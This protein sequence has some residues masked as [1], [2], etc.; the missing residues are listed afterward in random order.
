M[1]HPT[2]PPCLGPSGA[3]QGLDLRLTGVEPPGVLS[4]ILAQRWTVCFAPQTMG[5]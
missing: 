5:L 2:L 3:F 4:E 1:I